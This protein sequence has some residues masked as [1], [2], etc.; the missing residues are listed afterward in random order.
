MDLR[1]CIVF[2][3]LLVSISV[4]QKTELKVEKLLVPEGCTTKSK[5]GDMLTMH[6]TGTLTDGTKFDSR[7]LK[8]RNVTCRGAT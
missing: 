7:E 4:A 6:Y 5:S 1:P 2:A 3:V 8:E